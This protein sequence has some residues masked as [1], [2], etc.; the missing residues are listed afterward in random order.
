M[1]DILANLRK[2]FPS[3]PQNVLTKI[4]RTHAK[5]M[6]LLMINR[7]PVDIRWM[8]EARVHLSGESVD[9]YIPY[10]S[11]LGKNIYAQKRRAKQLGVCYKYE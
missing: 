6:R 7:M 8:I 1:E 10:M 4:Y 11:G 9:S 2:H 5:R 3:L